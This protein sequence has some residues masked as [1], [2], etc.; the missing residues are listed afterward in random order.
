MTEIKTCA[1][2]NLSWTQRLVHAY[3][4][5]KIQTR[6][7]GVQCLLA[8]YLLPE[9]EQ[10][11]KQINR[12]LSD[13]VSSFGPIGLWEGQYRVSGLGSIHFTENTSPHALQSLST[14]DESTHCTRC[15]TRIVALSRMIFDK[16]MCSDSSAVTRQ[17][18]YATRRHQVHALPV[19][20][21]WNTL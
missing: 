15:N 7:I 8:L 2:G 9:N 10:Q 21:H 6:A 18:K 14:W 1:K 16:W 19:C 12:P 20:M 3:I 17:Y 4:Y 13:A 11:Q 5:H